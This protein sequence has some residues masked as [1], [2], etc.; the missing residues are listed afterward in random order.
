MSHC[1][2]AVGPR[3]D[4]SCRS[5]DFTLY[6]Q[7]LFFAIIPNAVLLVLLVLPVARLLRAQDVVRRTK[8][9][10]VKAALYILLFTC[11]T[12]FLALRTR[13]PRLHTPASVAADTLAIMATL[14]AA[15]LSWLQHHRSEQPSALLAI[16][17]ALVSLLNVARAR[18][19]WLLPHSTGPAVLQTLVL[20]QGVGVLLVESVGKKSALRSPEKF[21]A[22]G[23][24]PFTGF[25]NLVGFS[26]LLGTL[27]R[28]YHSILSVDDLPDLD[29]RLDSESLREQ[30][31]ND[32]TEKRSLLLACFRAY[33]PSLL[34]AIFPRLILSALKFA[35]P[36]MITKLIRFV[37]D[38]DVPDDF[39]RG[40]I[41]AYALVYL[42]MAVGK[43]QS[44]ASTALYGYMTL[45]FLIRLR[46]GLIALI[47]QQTVEA[48]AVDLGSINGLTLMGTDVER[49]VLN[50]LTIHEVWAS[51]VEIGIA[52]FL[53]QRQVFVACLVPG[54]VTFGKIF[55][56]IIDV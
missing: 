18:S 8:S 15:S 35:Q 20:L 22:S 41:G 46:G 42:G 34:S 50:F 11:Q 13:Q 12:I 54:V 2:Q 9:V 53:L 44:L 37:G 49:I 5:F 19:L 30:L 10:A 51:L 29:Y 27:N 17:F 26:W 4:P 6:F 48:R 43:I 21:Q 36:F 33:A 1:D 3:V 23:P 32:K 31:A 45:R 56:T 40:L 16:F 55:V 7:D 47:Y 39:G 14:A 25:W 52:I 38:K 28:G 24:E